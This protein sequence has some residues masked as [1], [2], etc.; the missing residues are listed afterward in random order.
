MNSD[1]PD[2]ARTRPAHVRSDFHG[3]RFYRLLDACCLR[4]ASE[5]PVWGDE[6]CSAT[7]VGKRAMMT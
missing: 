1:G 6:I 4:M 3:G 5:R 7:S 2:W